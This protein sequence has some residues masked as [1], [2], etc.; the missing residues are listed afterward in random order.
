MSSVLIPVTT[1]DHGKTIRRRVAQAESLIRRGLSHRQVALK[2][3]LA[4]AAVQVIADRTGGGWRSKF[5]E[6]QQEYDLLRQE[7]RRV[8]ES[9][10]NTERDRNSLER[11]LA[12]R[13]SA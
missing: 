1:P 10:M 5:E 3:G 11:R 12:G 9:L 6:L 4:V 13:V 2:A 7:L 8:R